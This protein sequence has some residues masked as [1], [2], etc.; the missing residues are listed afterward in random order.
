VSK[1]RGDNSDREQMREARAGS[2]VV[3]EQP[4]A[5]ETREPVISV[6]VCSYNSRDEIDLSLGSLREQDFDEPY[7]VLV[8]DSGDDDTADYLRAAYPEVRLVRSEERLWPGPARNAGVRAARGD[9]VAFLP[10]DGVAGRDWLRRRVAKHREGFEA[11]GGAITNGTPWHP[12]GSAGYYLE[13]SALIPS[14]EVLAEQAIPHCLSYERALLERL[15]PFPEEA[16][17]G[18]DTLLNERLAA[19]GVEVGFDAGVQLDHLNLKGLAPY[20]EH[21]YNHGRGLAQCVEEYGFASQIGPAE[22]PVPAA[23]WRMFAAYPALRWWHALQRVWRGR[24]R[25][26]LGYL[27]VTP[28][29]WAGL[30]ATSVGA[31]REWRKLRAG[32]P[33]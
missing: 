26:V 4:S 14:E 6:I 12:V 7:E 11:V 20:L 31:W 22:Q 23:L 5:A 2:A 32:V 28:L 9:I 21:Q 1:G 18:E 30:W 27:F 15:G 19:A 24:R 25:W 13:Y 10:A 16:E 17:T 33:A 29:V 3:A 8:V